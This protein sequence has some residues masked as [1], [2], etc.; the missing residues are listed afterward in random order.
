LTKGFTAWHYLHM[1]IASPAPR[2]G[3]VIFIFITVV[4][5]M[6]SVGM[7]APVLPKL[8]AGFL[9]GDAV[10]TAELFGLSVTL[11]ALMQFFASPVLGVLS[12]R[13]GRRPVIVLS[14]LGLGLDYL[15]MALAPSV[16]WLFLGRAISGVSAASLTTAGAYIA[17]ITPPEKRAAGFG[18]ISAAFG[19]GFVLGPAVGGLLGGFNPRFPFWVAAA[20]SLANALY[21]TFV[22]PESLPPERRA[23]E[24]PWRRANPIGSLKLLRSHPELSSLSVVSFLSALSGQSLPAVWVLFTIFQYNWDA[25]AI[26]FSLA[27]FGI[28]TAIVQGGLVRPFV[29]RFGERSALLVGLTCGVISMTMLAFATTPFLFWTAIAVMAMW[30]FA[31]AAT[32]SFMSRRVSPMEQGELQGAIN[33]IRSFTSLIGPGLFTLTFAFFIAGQRTWHY[34]GA[35]WVL[36]AMIVAA[37]LPLAWLATRSRSEEMRESV[38]RVAS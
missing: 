5:D 7:I 29:A 26:G 30:G 15:V 27:M 12:D 14:N 38:E 23:A 9:G 31:A 18:M 11:W 25:R 3:A 34:A 24:I 8:F 16:G 37:A 35:A 32:Q 6:L 19:V 21:G 20:F 2:R 17:D 10:R 22:L 33:S 4:L 28:A 13:F 36:G 1:Q